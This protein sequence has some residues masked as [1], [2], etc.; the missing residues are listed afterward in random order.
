MYSQTRRRACTLAWCTAAGLPSQPSQ[1]WTHHALEDDAPAHLQAQV[2][3]WDSLARSTGTL[4]GCGIVAETLEPRAR[5]SRMHT[6]TH[7][8]DG[9]PHARTTADGDHLKVLRCWMAEVCRGSLARNTHL[10]KLLGNG[11]SSWS[12]APRFQSIAALCR[13]GFEVADLVQALSPRCPAASVTVGRYFG[14]PVAR[15]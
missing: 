4:A 2:H 8:M 10:Y 5:T 12:P 15:R 9:H 3:C 14:R 6:Q 13:H 1:C 11:D 7:H